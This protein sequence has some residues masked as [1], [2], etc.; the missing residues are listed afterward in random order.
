LIN[1]PFEVTRE[2]VQAIVQHLK[3]GGHWIELG[4]PETRWEQEGRMPFEEWGVKTDGGAPW[5]EWKDLPK[6]KALLEPIEFETVLYFDFHD[7]DFNWFD[8]VRKSPSGN[9]IEAAITPARVNDL[10]AAMDVSFG[11]L[12]SRLQASQEEV[13]QLQVQLHSQF[14]QLQEELTVT[15][16]ELAKTQVELQQNKDMKERIQIVLGNQIAAMQSSK[17]WQLRNQWIS[18]RKRLKFLR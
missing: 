8:L 16:M 1:S 14:S 2:E 13:V 12:A 18:F 4:Y 6:V 9:T 11:H 10:V 3:E 17:F 7:G 5:I 15:K